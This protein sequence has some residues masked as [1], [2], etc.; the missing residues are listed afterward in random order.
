[1]RELENG[2]EQVA[3]IIIGNEQAL[4]AIEQ[5]DPDDRIKRLFGMSTDELRSRYKNT[6]H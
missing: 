1:M 6:S 2:A 4:D 5:D 3:A